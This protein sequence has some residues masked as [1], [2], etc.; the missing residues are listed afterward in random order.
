MIS[1]VRTVFRL[2]GR[3]RRASL[4]VLCAGAVM[5]CGGGASSMVG[6]SASAASASSAAPLSGEALRR[7]LVG[8]DASS[9][10]WIPVAHNAEFPDED[11]LLYASGEY[12]T[13]LHQRPSSSGHFRLDGDNLYLD[14][15][16]GSG[17][18]TIAGLRLQGDELR[19]SVEGAPLVLRRHLAP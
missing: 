6:S 8:G 18:L 15:W 12:F 14:G 3:A 19:G 4:V 17:T 10:F 16:H 1:I 11:L 5:A 2:S 7:A 13:H 9:E